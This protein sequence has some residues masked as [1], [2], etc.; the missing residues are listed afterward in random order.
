[1][2]KAERLVYFYDMSMAAFSRT[3]AAPKSIS[4][5]RAFEL[6]EL[7]PRDQ[8]IKESASGQEILYVADWDTQDGLLCILVSKSDKSISDPVLPFPR[9]RSGER[10]RRKTRKGRISQYTSWSNFQ[11]KMRTRLLS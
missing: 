10:R 11:T 4:V 6:M 8:R 5:R 7:V 3:F 1:M 9:R 2:K